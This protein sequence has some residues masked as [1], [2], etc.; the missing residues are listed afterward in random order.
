MRKYIAPLPI[1]ILLVLA[2]C[3]SIWSDPIFC[4]F[5]NSFEESE[6]AIFSCENSLTSVSGKTLDIAIQPKPWE[7]KLT[8]VN[9]EVEGCS[10][11]EEVA[12]YGSLIH[13]EMTCKF[14]SHTKKIIV[15]Y[16]DSNGN[17][18]SQ[19]GILFNDIEDAK[20]SI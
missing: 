20:W 16:V 9:I 14:N 1:L 5:G 13:Y 11:N 2:G 4:Q 17:A 3:S 8:Q 19:E 6:A 15:S 10:L 7:D 18:K 12:N